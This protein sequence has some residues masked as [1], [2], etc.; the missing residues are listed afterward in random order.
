MPTLPTSRTL[1]LAILGAGLAGV[2][3]LHY[4]R[5][6][7]LDALVIDRADGVGGL[8]RDLPD[9]QDIQICPVDWTVG[10]IPITGPMRAEIVAN[11]EQWVPRFGLADGLCLGTPVT[12]ARHNGSCWELHTPQGVLRARHLVAATGAHNVPSVPEVRRSAATVRELHSSQLREPGEL[13]GRSVMVV[14]GGASA[15]DLL[16]QCLQHGAS[17][18][19][20]VYRGLRWFTPTTKPK[21]VAGSFRPFAKLQANRVPVAKQNELINADMQARYAKFGLQALLPAQPLDVLHDQI[22]P[23]RAR[24]LQ[25]L[26]A[27]TRHPGA[28]VQAIEGGEVLLSDGSRERPDVLL[29]GTGYGTSL[30]CFESPAIAGI[31]SVAGLSA[32]C[33]CIMRSLD[34]PDLYFPGVGLDGIGATSWMFAIG[35]R[36]IMSHIRGTARL[37]MVPTPHKMNHLDM[38]AHLAARDPASYPEGR[39]LEYY[40]ELTLTL[41]DDQ[42]YP[43]P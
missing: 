4:A 36:T 17:R 15:F 23:G 6:A 5:Q 21:A 10:D 43:M 27:L 32:R 1:D 38:V 12:L 7:G 37:D 39:G 33:G 40:R 34:A 25:Q 28:T 18:I 11:V 13:A 16:D 24:M 9:W 22:I 19:A 29:W 20:W 42:P 26:D 35:A 31:T 14:G 41:P 30:R 8:W 3:H 2:V